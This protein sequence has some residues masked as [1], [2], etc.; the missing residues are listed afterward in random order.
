MS[1]YP[2]WLH[3]DVD[4]NVMAV[5]LAGEFSSMFFETSEDESSFLNKEVADND[6]IQVLKDEALKLGIKVD[7]RWS[8][9]RLKEE[10]NKAK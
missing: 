6:T 9:E 5:P 2:K 4:G 8:L 1:D 3:F 7:G 10:I